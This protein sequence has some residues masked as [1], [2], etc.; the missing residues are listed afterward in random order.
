MATRPTVA[1]IG[2]GFAG[3]CMAV[4]LKK[5]GYPF[6]IFEKSARVGGT[7]LHNSYPGVACDVPSCLYA[8]SFELKYDWKRKYAEGAE[9]LAYLEHCVTKFELAGHIKFETEV[10]LAHFDEENGCW[11]LK[12]SS[13]NEY[14]AGYLVS[15][16][17]Q[18]DRPFIP[19]L[20]GGDIFAGRQFHSARWQHDHEMSGRR[21][22]VIGTGA[23]GVQLVPAIASQVD[24]LT[25]F[26]RSAHW[27]LGKED[28]ELS[29]FEHRL[30]RNWPTSL[31]VTRLLSYLTNEIRFAVHSRNRALSRRGEELLLQ[32]MAR[33]VENP[34]LHAALRPTYPIGCRRTLLSNDYYQALN[35]PHVELV[36]EAI[37]RLEPEGV[38]TADGRHF[39]VDTLVYATGFRSTSF[40]YPIK[41]VGRAG[42][43]MAEAWQAGAHAYLG[44]AVAGFPN[45][46][47]L[48]G[49]NTSLGHNSILFM[50]EC[51]A[52]YVMNCLQLV[53]K[54]KKRCI[55]VQPEAM[56]RYG[57]EMQSHLTRRSARYGCT[58]EGEGSVRDWPFS[59]W[60]YRLRTR[61]VRPAD[62]EFS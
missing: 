18:L 7:W 35:L 23:S 53:H 32:E 24:R 36:T 44:L 15:G 34:L 30:Y 41:V 38:V 11:T 51:Q 28:R 49:P 13:G 8:F 19:E 16:S 21:V 39:E 52:R 40:L 2:A 47:I 27:I 25:I 57:L 45:L 3:L 12:C 10:S 46:F 14:Q 33:Q 55:E 31:R 62:F 54:K 48:Y 61:R 1:I 4:H 60:L 37:E 22:A 50:I 6:T 29:A 43:T 26:Q 42:T 9:I 56:R 20:R 58:P 5:A 59:S 17:G